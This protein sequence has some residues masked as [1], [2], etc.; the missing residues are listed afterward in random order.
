MININDSTIS[1]K[2]Y[3]VFSESEVKFNAASNNIYTR[4]SALNHANAYNYI[5]RRILCK[6]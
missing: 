6:T 4:I 1:R 2:L 5:I 3:S